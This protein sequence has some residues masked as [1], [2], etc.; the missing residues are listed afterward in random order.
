MPDTDVDQPASDR[1][2]I[3]PANPG[4]LSRRIC[5]LNLRANAASVCRGHVR[6]TI[7]MVRWP[8]SWRLHSRLDCI[9]AVSS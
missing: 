6:M 5:S 3:F 4:P 7:N 1:R 8:R 9:Y 2:S